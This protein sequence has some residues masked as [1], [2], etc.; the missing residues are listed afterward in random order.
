M[1]WLKYILIACMFCFLPFGEKSNTGKA[2][3]ASGSAQTAWVEESEEVVTTNRMYINAQ[4]WNAHTSGSAYFQGALSQ[5]IWH[6]GFY[7]NTVYIY[8]QSSKGNQ[9]AATYI[10]N[11]KVYMVNGYGDQLLYQDKYLL[12]NYGE[13]RAVTNLYCNM[14]NCIYYITWDT[15]TSF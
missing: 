2:A 12:I 11:F 13:T 1:K 15:V 10:T 7:W 9:P 4:N 5:T 6:N 3:V 8:G 14:P